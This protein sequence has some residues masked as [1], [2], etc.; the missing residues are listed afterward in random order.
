MAPQSSCRPKRYTARIESTSRPSPTARL[1]AP[2]AASD[3]TGPLLPRLPAASGGVAT[4]GMSDRKGRIGGVMAVRMLA[5]VAR[6]TPGRWVTPVR[7]APDRPRPRQRYRVGGTPC[8]ADRVACLPECLPGEAIPRAPV[9]ARFGPRPA[10][11][12]R[13]RFGPV[14]RTWR[15]HGCSA[16]PQDECRPGRPGS[17]R[18]RV[19]G[20]GTGPDPHGCPGRR[21]EAH[22]A[23]LA[24]AVAARRRRG[25]G[26]DRRRH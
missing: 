9:T 20:R 2:S 18:R 5:Y 23:G 17:A 26:G 25:V 8:I 13:G 21:D 15:P 16:A 11:L 12:V 10:T 19:P 4:L 24:V 3:S 7:L 22:A 14:V 1:P 6:E